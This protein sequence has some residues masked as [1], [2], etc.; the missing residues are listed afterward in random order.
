MVTV[1]IAVAMVCFV[2][3]LLDMGMNGGGYA[4]WAPWGL[5]VTVVCTIAVWAMT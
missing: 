3:A 4:E 1:L 2:T 5:G